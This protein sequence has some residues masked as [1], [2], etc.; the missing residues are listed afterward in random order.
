MIGNT[1][2]HQ[3]NLLSQETTK[4]EGQLYSEEVR[5]ATLVVSTF[6]KCVRSTAYYPAEHVIARQYRQE[7]TALFSDYLAVYPMLAVTVSEDSLLF[8]EQ[9]I[10]QQSDLGTSLAFQLYRDGVRELRFSQELTEHELLRLL[11]IISTAPGRDQQDDDLV[12]LLWEQE[13]AHIDFIAID[14]LADELN[15][16]MRAETTDFRAPAELPQ[17]SY[18]EWDDTPVE[19]LEGTLGDVVWQHT[20]FRLTEEEQAQLQADVDAELEAEAMFAVVDVVFSVFTLETRPEPC[21]DAADYLVKC[22]DARLTVAGVAE[23]TALLQQVHARLDD[24]ALPAWQRPLL[25][26]IITQASDASRVERVGR[27]LERE[28]AVPAAEIEAYLSLLAPDAIV[29]LVEL[30]G[31]Q[32]RMST[33][34]MLCRTLARIGRHAVGTLA[35]YLRTSS[36]FVV[37]NIASVLGH[38]GRAECVPPLRTVC[39]HPEPRVRREVIEALGRIGGDEAV[40]LLGKALEDSES[41]NRGSAAISLGHIGTPGAVQALA[42]AVTASDFLKKELPEIKQYCAGLRLSGREEAVSAL[43][44]HLE[45]QPLLGR[46]KADAVRTVAAL[47]LA[48]LGTPGAHAALAAGA[49]SRVSAI[50][51]ACQQALASAPPTDETSEGE[52]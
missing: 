26:S 21:Q 9:I 1:T 22:L 35:P 31:G 37:R 18:E 29:P 6:A 32:Q 28:S 16:V 5:R 39:N 41:A 7:L 43:R 52:Q 20:V 8:D 24:P 13:F 12:T 46:A 27:L 38:I 17:H 10:Y 33:R 23:A 42:Q 2:D 25:Q 14:D 40:R 3:A 50:R 47:A 30:L 11:D 49:A 45:R 19:A 51:E 15:F 4:Y 44:R 36:W 34:A 48:H